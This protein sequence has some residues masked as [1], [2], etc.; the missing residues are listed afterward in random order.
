MKYFVDTGAG[1]EIMTPIYDIQYIMK[2]MQQ[3]Q[4]SVFITA[5]GNERLNIHHEVCSVLQ[6]KGTILVVAAEEG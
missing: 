4:Y 5:L 2:Q 6:N 1:L 3:H